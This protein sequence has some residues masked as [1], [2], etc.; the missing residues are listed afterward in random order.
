MRRRGSKGKG[1]EERGKV[2]KRG[3]R[4]RVKKRVVKR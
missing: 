2:G 1:K 4:I 3:V